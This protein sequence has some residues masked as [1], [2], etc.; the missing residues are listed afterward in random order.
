M[1]DLT[2]FNMDDSAESIAR[3]IAIVRSIS[4]I[5]SMLRIL[6][7]STGMGFAAVARVTDGTWTAC[8]VED[9]IQFGLQPGGRL[10]VHTTLCSEARAA[11][12]PVVFDHAS[13]DPVYKYHHTPRLYN[14]ESYISVPIVL[15]NGDYFGNLCAIDPHPKTISKPETVEVFKRFAELISMQLDSERRRENAEIKLMS[16]LAQNELREHFI[17]VLGHD[18]RNPVQSIAMTGEILVRR[19][20]DAQ[21]VVMGQRLRATSIR[22]TNLINDVLDFAQ[23]KLGTGIAVNLEGEETLGKLL[24]DVVSELRVAHPNRKVLSDIYIAQ[25]ISCD[26]GRVQQLL[27]NLLGNALA[28]GAV[29]QAIVVRANVKGANLEISVTN[30]GKPI[31][32]EMHGKIFEPYWRPSSSKPGGGLG[33]GLYIC[34]QIVKAHGGALL[35]TSSVDG[36]RFLAQLPLN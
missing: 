6:C 8:A 23:G 11:N 22:M 24:E 27:S 32:E 13:E 19:A 4:A 5:P 1:P 10:D 7:K 25:S 18:L 31:P 16:E 21:L 20:E 33:L 2:L 35:V 29:D 28:H 26:R 9:N 36:T 34:S 15:E 3:D 17:A 14:I 12:K 30:A